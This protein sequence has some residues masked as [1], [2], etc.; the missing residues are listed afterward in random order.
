MKGF[1]GI[2]FEIISVII[3]PFIF[4]SFADFGLKND[5]CGET[6]F[7]SPNH[8]TSIY[9]LITACVLCFYYCKIRSKLSPPLIEVFLN[10]LLVAG[11]TL[12]IFISIHE[13]E[14]FWLI[15]NL[16]IMVI[17]FFRLADNQ[18]LF[19]ESFDED[20]NDS[21]RKLNRV[22][23]RIL[24]LN[25]FFQIPVLFVIAFPVLLFI[26]VALML[27][28]Q[29]PDSMVRAFTDTY[30]QGFSQLDYQCEDV[31]C[32]S[33]HYLCT[34]AA[35]GHHYLVKP[36]RYGIR[37][38]KQIVCN[39]QLLI[40]NAFEEILQETLPGF[41]KYLRRFYDRI[42]NFVHCY[43]DVLNNTFVSDFIYILM[44]P[45]EW[46]FLVCIYCLEKKPENRIFKQYLK[47]CDRKLL[48]K[49]SNKV[50][51]RKRE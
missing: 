43:Y 30:K 49:M 36:V 27:F 41:H 15:G 31:I 35:K 17:F 24:R 48:D 22:A 32:P 14:G 25:V 10:S 23:R 37:G 34:V 4:L 8:R 6:A 26:A 33:G 1:F 44:K 20:Q 28:G 38:N 18:K 40:S 9:V 7:F 45:F 5:C 29:R 51:E 47:P 39:R 42:G 2:V 46:L 11:I 13:T 12:N 19:L 21:D 3:A 16:P 50:P